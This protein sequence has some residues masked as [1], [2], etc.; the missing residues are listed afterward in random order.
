[1]SRKKKNETKG[2]IYGVYADMSER[3]FK[4]NIKGGNVTDVKRFKAR[5]GGN[6]NTPVLL[7]FEGNILPARVFIGCLSFLVREY[8]RPPLR[9]FKCRRYG[10]VAASCR[11]NRLCAKCGGD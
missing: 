3:E 8:Q 9:C 2:V 1:M 6:K 5:E 11:G 10:Y 7:T 4:E